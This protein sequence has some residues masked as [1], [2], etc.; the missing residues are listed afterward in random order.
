MGRAFAEGLLR[1]GMVSHETLYL[2]E[3]RNERRD[4][5]RAEL[6]CS[7]EESVTTLDK[8]KYLMLAVKPQDLSTAAATIV[9]LLKP[10]TIVISLLAGVSTTVLREA[11][12]GHS[13]IIRAMPNLPAIIGAGMTAFYC[14]DAIS[15]ETQEEAARIFDGVGESLLLKNEQMLNAV[16]AISGSGPAY[17]YYFLHAWKAAAQ[18]LG[19]SEGEANILISQTL[20]GATWLWTD[21]D[22]DEEGLRGR[23]TSKGGTTEAAIKVLTE[24]DVAAIF[25][26]AVRRAAERGADLE[27]LVKENL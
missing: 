5:L 4:A 3:R 11:L 6:G 13:A 10:D 8:S 22:H 25:R 9:P 1:A 18:E 23:V 14:V 27:K 20:T 21:S 15:Q 2:V 12:G 16:T 17:L 7:C 19:F 24:G 26:R